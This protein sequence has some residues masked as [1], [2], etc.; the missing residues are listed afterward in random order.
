M[1]IRRKT[2]KADLVRDFLKRKG[3]PSH[4]VRGG[5]AGLVKNWENVVRSVGQGYPLG[6]ED[7]LNDL[8]GRQLLEEA[9]TLPPGEQREK[10]LERVKRADELMKTYVRPA[11][12]CL[13]GEETA[14]AEGWTA[15]KNWWYFTQP[16]HANPELLSEIKKA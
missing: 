6:L 12:T 5:L 3:C 15:E 13:W 16:I 8:D 4:V 11:G 1:V 9:L 10:H 7:Y 14:K 2:N